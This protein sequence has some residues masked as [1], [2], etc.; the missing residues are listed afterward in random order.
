LFVAVAFPG[1]ARAQPDVEIN[2]RHHRF[3][4]ANQLAQSRAF[5]T[6]CRARS[7]SGDV[8]FRF[9]AQGLSQFG[10]LDFSPRLAANFPTH[11]VTT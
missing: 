3:Q 6:K 4:R 1:D 11:D 7:A 10:M 5:A 2:R 8:P 9:R